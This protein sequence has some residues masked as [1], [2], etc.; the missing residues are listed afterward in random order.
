MKDKLTNI[1]VVAGVTVVVLWIMA[2]AF[3]ASSYSMSEMKQDVV[4]TSVESK[5]VRSRH[6]YHWEYVGYYTLNFDGESYDLHTGRITIRMQEGDVYSCGFNPDNPEDAVLDVE[7]RNSQSALL[8]AF[9]VVAVL[10]G[11]C[12]FNL[13]R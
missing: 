4:I 7:S 13:R 6:S 2:H 3:I 9:I 10:A 5:R 12:T 8:A 11:I 1:F